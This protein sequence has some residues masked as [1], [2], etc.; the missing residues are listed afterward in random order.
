MYTLTLDADNDETA[1][2]ELRSDSAATPTTVRCS[3]SLAASDPGA[4]TPKIVG[5][6]QLTY[7]VPPAHTVKLVTSGSGVVTLTHQT[8]MVIS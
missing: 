1:T 7:V 4:A 5:R 3:A 8:E 6:Q 2:C